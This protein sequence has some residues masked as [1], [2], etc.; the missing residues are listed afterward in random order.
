MLEMG[1][2]IKQFRKKNNLPQSSLANLMRTTQ[3]TI[4]LWELGKS[5]PDAESIVRMAKLFRTSSDYLLGL[6]DSE[7]KNC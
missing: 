7:S 4:S 5:Y 6:S 3:D 2:R 1:G